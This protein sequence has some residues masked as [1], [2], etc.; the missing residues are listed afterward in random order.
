MFSEQKTLFYSIMW[1]TKRL[2]DIKRDLSKLN[3][4]QEFIY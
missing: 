3:L 4:A 1:L 2:F